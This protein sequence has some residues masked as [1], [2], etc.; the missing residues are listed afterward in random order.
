MQIRTITLKEFQDFSENWE[1]QNFHQSISYEDFIEGIKPVL[2][3]Q[4]DESEKLESKNGTIE[5]EV[6]DGIFKKL[7][8]T[9]KGVSGNIDNN[10][11]V[12]F[13]NKKFYKFY[14]LN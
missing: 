6:K 3:S 10:Q 13:Q 14:T 7:S 9:A 4:E 12:E 5:Y 8:N 11:V 1:H 2:N